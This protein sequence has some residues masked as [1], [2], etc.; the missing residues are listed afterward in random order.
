MKSVYHFAKINLFPSSN[1][2][3]LAIRSF[4]IENKGQQ[5]VCRIL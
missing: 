5:N 1:L 4:K 3:S 2:H